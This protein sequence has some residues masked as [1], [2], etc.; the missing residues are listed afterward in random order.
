LFAA[1]AIAVIAEARRRRNTAQALA[2]TAR[3]AIKVP[4]SN[5][6]GSSLDEDFECHSPKETNAVWHSAATSKLRVWSTPKPHRPTSA[7]R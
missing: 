4:A 2:A 7:A 5:I 6:L 1:A 3:A